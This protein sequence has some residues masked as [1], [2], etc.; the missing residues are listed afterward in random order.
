MASLSDVFT[1]SERTNWLKAWLAIDIAKSAIEQ[2]ADNEAKILHGNIYNAILTNGTVACTGC[3]TA[4]LLKCP[5]PGICNKRGANGISTS[6]HDTQ[7]SRQCP[8]NVCN[9]V[10]VEIA[11]QQYMSK[12]FVEKYSCDSLGIKSVAN[13]QGLFTYR[14]LY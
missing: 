3:H 1:D 6:M 14:W 10:L 9:K 4:N 7:Q 11:K 12:P 5:S 2:F 8:G 13:T